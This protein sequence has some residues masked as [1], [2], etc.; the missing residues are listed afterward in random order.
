[1]PIQIRSL[2]FFDP[3]WLNFVLW[4]NVDIHFEDNNRRCKYICQKLREYV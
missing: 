4:A 2:Y 1:M 3:R